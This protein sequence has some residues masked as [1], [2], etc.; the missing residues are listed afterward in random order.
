MR[1]SVFKLNEVELSIVRQ[2]SGD[3]VVVPY[4]RFEDVV[5]TDESQLFIINAGLSGYSRHDIEEQIFSNESFQKN[6]IILLIDDSEIEINFPSDTWSNIDFYRRPLI[7]NSLKVRISFHLQLMRARTCAQEKVEQATLIEAILSQSPVGIML[8]HDEIAAAE[9]CLEHF[10][11]NP[12]VEEIMG[13]SKEEIKLLSIADVTH[14]DDLQSD[15]DNLHRLNAGE[16]DGYA[17]DKRYIRP[18][19]TAIWVHIV[20]APISI[21][22]EERPLQ[23]CYIFDVSER[24]KLEIALMESERSKSVLLSHLPGMAYRCEVDP[25]WTMRFVSAGCIGLTGY[26]PEDLINNNKLSYNQIIAPEYRTKLWKEWERI[27]PKKR[28]FKDEYEIITAD[29]SRKW[30]ME[31][32]QGIYDTDGKVEALE[33]IILDITERKEIERELVNF[34]EHDQWTGLNNRRAFESLLR[35]ESR[36]RSK[37]KRA[38]IGINLSTLHSLSTTYGFDY[39]QKVVHKISEEFKRLSDD[40]HELFNTYVNRFVFFVRTYEDKQEL[41]S[42]CKEVSRRLKSILTIERIGWGIGIIELGNFH[43]R[44]INKLLRNLLVASEKSLVGFE[45]DMDCFFFDEQ[46]ELEI[47]REKEIILELSE[48]AAGQGKGRLYLHFQPIVDIKTDAICGFEAL[49]R[50]QSK[51]LGMISPMEFIPIAEKTKLMIPLGWNILQQAFQFHKRLCKNRFDFISISINISP[52]QLLRKEFLPNLMSMME[53]VGVTPHLVS[54][55]ITE[56]IFSSNYQEVNKIL[57]Q[58]KDLGFHIALDDFG[59]GYSSFAREREL[60]I[61]CLK[62][63]KYFIDKLMYLEEHEA[64]TG[65]IISMVHR[66]GHCVVA[67]GVEHEKQRDYLKRHGCDKIQGYLISKPVDEDAAIELLSTYNITECECHKV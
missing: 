56:S 5:Q 47:E 50:L 36:S 51:K 22:S 41:V 32:A 57:G 29:G 19:G 21:P 60:N 12:M 44:G 2:C 59:T 35:L 9:N 53:K 48:I 25:Q 15:L 8:T 49:A 62:I 42:F 39:A 27:L 6:Q 4:S 7:G 43:A 13:R 33:G 65:D 23:I 64:I 18:D 54:F 3:C 46:M 17:M 20:V 45:D 24:K 38:I 14:P 28:L 63:D 52:V 11:I 26:F 66:L 10:T 34:N 61:N 58:L 37:T 31:A 16:I 30:V 55:E 1:I 40:N 67:E